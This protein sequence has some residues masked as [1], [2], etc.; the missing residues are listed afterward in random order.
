LGFADGAQGGQ[1]ASRVNVVSLQGFLDGV[2]CAERAADAGHAKGDEG[3]GGGWPPP[4]HL[5]DRRLEN[6]V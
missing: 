4:E 1:H 2:E 6:L 5:G 3:L